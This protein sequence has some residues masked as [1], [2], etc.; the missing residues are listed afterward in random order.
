MISTLKLMVWLTTVVM[1][2]LV[3]GVPGYH[4]FDYKNGYDTNYRIRIM[5]LKKTSYEVI[6]LDNDE[7]RNHQH[8]SRY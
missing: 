5:N 8:P 1:A 3:G 4:L 6:P 7:N 2:T